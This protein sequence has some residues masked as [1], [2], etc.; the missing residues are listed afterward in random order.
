[1][2]TVTLGEI[3]VL[4]GGK[5]SGDESH[6][7]SG[8]AALDEAGPVEL[9]FLS[10][11]R[12]R[13]LLKDSDAGGIIVSLDVEIEGK[14][15]IKVKDPYIGFAKAMDYFYGDPMPYQGISP[16][17]HVH[18]GAVL[19]SQ[20]SVQPFAVICEGA[21][22][23]DGVTLMAGCYVGPDV[24]I[25]SGSAIHPNVTIE[26]GCIIGRNVIIHA[27]TVIGSDGYGF[28]PDGKKHRKIIQT[29]IVRIG[30][31]VEF[32]AGCAIDRA[33]LGETV[34]G[35]GTKLDNNVHIAHNARIGR[36]CLLVAGVGISGSVVVEDNVIMA[37]HS[38]V[39]GHL[40]V[41]EGA[42]LMAKAA[43]FKDVPAGSV[44]AGVPAIE[45]SIWKRSVAVFARL[46]ALKKQVSRLEKELNV[47]KAR[48]REEQ[49]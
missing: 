9:S 40:R 45:S 49:D 7:V 27:G 11:P 16:M 3:A 18:P 24:S 41:G 8:I 39:A 35:D 23:D 37:G 17:A 47:I 34:I 46:D 44:V 6:S 36:N 12:Y 28:A 15:L 21:N 2:K 32:G 43:T 5:V 19:G 14:N 30:D 33:T 1:M 26:K 10:N 25:G 31:D 4:L 38:G 29:G 42:V 48:E 22:V 20:V 13:P